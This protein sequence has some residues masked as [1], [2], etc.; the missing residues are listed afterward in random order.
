MP[1]PGGLGEFKRILEKLKWPPWA[2]VRV[3]INF[4]TGFWASW[5]TLEKPNHFLEVIKEKFH[6]FF[7]GHATAG[8]YPIQPKIDYFE[9]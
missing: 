3:E 5:S 7:S 6:F 9:P 8:S 4:E 2:R 1:G